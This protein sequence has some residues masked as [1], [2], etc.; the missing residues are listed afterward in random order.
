MI[1]FDDPVRSPIDAFNEDHLEKLWTSYVDGWLSRLEMPRKQIFVMTPWI[2]GDPADRIMQGAEESGENVKIF[3]CKSY[4][5]SQGMLCTDILNKRTFDILKVRLD[6]IIF[7]GNYLCT[8]LGLAGKLYTSFNFYKKD[9]LPTKFN[10][11]YA[12][13]DTADEGTDFL[14]CVVVGILRT[15]DE[16]GLKIKKAYVLDIL[17]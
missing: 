11:I 15:T 3:N 4:T 6:P 5:E 17:Y 16:F 14:A 8:R 9:D 13:V 10:E 12:Y 7:S 1:I 2:S